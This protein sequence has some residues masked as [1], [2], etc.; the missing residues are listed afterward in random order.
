MRRQFGGLPMIMSVTYDTRPGRTRALRRTATR[1][2]DAYRA[3]AQATESYGE[4]VA[5]AESY[6]ASALDDYHAMRPWRTARAA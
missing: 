2:R 3:L 1:L 6:V 4:S 5:E